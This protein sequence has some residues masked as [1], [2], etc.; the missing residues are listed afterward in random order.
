MNAHMLG[1]VF[2]MYLLKRLLQPEREEENA[3]R[4]TIW[5]RQ[6]GELLILNLIVGAHVLIQ[7]IP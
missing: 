1:V 3:C 6:K 4:Q 5:S 7:Y 2:F